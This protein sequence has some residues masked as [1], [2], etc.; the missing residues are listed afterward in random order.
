MFEW[1][2]DLNGSKVPIIKPLPIPAATAVAQGEIVDFTPGTGVIKLGTDGVDFDGPA[3]GVATHAHAANSGSTLKVSASPTAVYR[4]NCGQILTATGGSATTFVVATLV[5]ATN[6]LW[7]GGMLEVV[8]CAADSSLIGKRIP[9]TAS[10]GATGTLTFAAQTAGFAAGD[11]AR[12]CPG[13][14]AIRTT[15][16]NL[17]ANGVNV[18]WAQNATTGESLVLVDVDPANM[19]AFFMLRLHRFGNG[20]AAL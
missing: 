7:V 11:T 12:L 1:A 8:T 19:L 17:D 15:V 10:T 20:P 5:P 9:I 13:P 18:D 2:Y 4:H 14:F 16:W 6:N 3:V